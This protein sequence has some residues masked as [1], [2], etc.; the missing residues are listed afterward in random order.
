MSYFLAG[1]DAGDAGAGAGDAGAGAGAGEDDLA[2]VCNSDAESNVP[3]L[4]VLLDLRYVIIFGDFSLISYSLR[5]LSSN[6][7]LS[8]S[9]SVES[10][11]IWELA[12]SFVVSGFNGA[13]CN[14]MESRL[15]I[16]AGSPSSSILASGSDSIEGGK[17]YDQASSSSFI[18]CI[19]FCFKTL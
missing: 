19:F 8:F 9:L 18:S 11:D 12:S 14:G 4:I 6:L 1:G 5:F 3:S 15:L 10:F 2:I 13:F 16:G 7:G 17:Q